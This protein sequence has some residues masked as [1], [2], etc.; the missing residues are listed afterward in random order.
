M[1]SQ[2]R[3]FSSVCQALKSFEQPFSHK[4]HKEHRMHHLEFVNK[5][6]KENPLTKNK[7][8]FF[9]FHKTAF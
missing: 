8:I 3:G 6:A 5:Q 9:D 7:Q 1:T 2:L 4:K